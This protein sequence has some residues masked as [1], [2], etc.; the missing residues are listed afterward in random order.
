MK[1]A[2]CMPVHG[3]LTKRF[4]LSAFNIIIDALS[5]GVERDGSVVIPELKP[6]MASSADNGFNRNVLTRDA[7]DWGADYLLFA[8]V[9]HFI[10]VHGLRRLLSLNRE[11]VGINYR[12][13][14]EGD[15]DPTAARRRSDDAYD[16]VWTTPEK[17]SAGLV[18]QV[19]AMGL[20]FCL[21]AR[22]VFEK[23]REQAL[24]DGRES[25]WPIFHFAPIEGALHTLGEDGIFFRKCA[26][27]NIPLYVDHRLSLE[28]AHMAEVPLMFEQ[29]SGRIMS[30]LP[31]APV[32]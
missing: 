16:L 22:S 21:I 5:N 19:D 32:R 12:R 20:G 1:I 14:G 8:D 18:E 25:V 28:S 9:D 15:N 24:A 7:L 30:R 3:S 10:P 26:A 11:I 4:A 31:I 29:F 17:A 13:R 27:A 6:F 2:L 23:L